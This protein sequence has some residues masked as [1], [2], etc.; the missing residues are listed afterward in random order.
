DIGNSSSPT[1]FPS[2]SIDHV[3]IDPYVPNREAYA[4]APASTA[5]QTYPVA[6]T[7]GPIPFIIPLLCVTAWYGSE[8]ADSYAFIP[9]SLTSSPVNPLL[10]RSLGGII[11]FARA[12]DRSA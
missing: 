10:S 2:W 9:H 11:H 7:T 6:I 12:S 4:C 8:A 5:R 3:D 1:K